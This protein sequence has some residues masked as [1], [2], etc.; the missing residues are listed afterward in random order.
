MASHADRYNRESSSSLLHSSH[1]LSA[2][3]ARLLPTFRFHS[4]PSSSS[5]SPLSSTS[6]ALTS[7]KADFVVS[8]AQFPSF[9]FWSG[10]SRAALNWIMKGQRSLWAMVWAT[11]TWALLWRS[12]IALQLIASNR[13]DFRKSINQGGRK[14]G[15][16]FQSY[17]V[18]CVII[19]SFPAGVSE[20][21]PPGPHSRTQVKEVPYLVGQKTRLACGLEDRRL[22][23]LF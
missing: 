22:W 14:K 23:P 18:M 19:K 13:S 3:L 9:F 16:H 20:P 6:S 8:S 1:V 2:I 17:T 7:A 5:F 15:F 4:R 21:S 11:W 12:Q 10:R